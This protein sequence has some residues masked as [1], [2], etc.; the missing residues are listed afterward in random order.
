[1]VKEFRGEIASTFAGG[2]AGGLFSKYMLNKAK[3]AES[4]DP[5]VNFGEWAFSVAPT[6]MTV[7]STAL[8]GILGVSLYT[9]SKNEPQVKQ[10][11]SE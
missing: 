8:F 2:G 3:A 9:L 10:Q 1:M 4:V 5:G 6:V 7:L 11:E